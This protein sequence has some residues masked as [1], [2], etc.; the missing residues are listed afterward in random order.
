MAIRVTRINRTITVRLGASSAR[1]VVASEKAATTLLSTLQELENVQDIDITA[2]ADRTLLMFDSS[3]QK[4]I[5][6]D[7][8]LIH[9]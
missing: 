2:R 6:V 9:I 4:Y 5:H 1:K 3:S 7:L 8:S